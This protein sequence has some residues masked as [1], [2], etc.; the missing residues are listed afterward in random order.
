MWI[1]ISSTF[2]EFYQKGV[3]WTFQAKTV[4]FATSRIYSESAQKT[5]PENFVFLTCRKS[6][7]ILGE[8]A[9]FG[10]F[11]KKNATTFFFHFFLLKNLSWVVFYYFFFQN[12]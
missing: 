10:L 8:K 12:S 6:I 1:F 2:W 11:R 3:L 9:A 7:E 5:L 4:P